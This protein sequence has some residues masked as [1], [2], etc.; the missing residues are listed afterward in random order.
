[1]R[2]LL[3]LVI[4]LASF[5]VGS[6]LIGLLTQDIPGLPPLIRVFLNII[7]PVFLLV[8]IFG[9]EGIARAAGILQFAMPAAVLVAIVAMEHNLQ[10]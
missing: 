1:M 8:S 10:F 4:F 3:L 6:G 5:L 2:T 9:L 7:T